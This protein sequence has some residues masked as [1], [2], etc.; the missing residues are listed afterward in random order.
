MP[1]SCS[2][3]SCYAIQQSGGSHGSGAYWIQPSS[4]PQPIRAYCDMETSGGGWTLLLNNVGAPAL[5][6]ATT[7]YNLNAANPSLT[8][9]H[10]LLQYGNE[11]KANL[12]GARMNY[13]IDAVSLGRW[14]GVW[15]APY[16]ANLETN[17][18]QNVATMIEKYD[19]GLWT[20]DTDP[21]DAN[22]TQ[23]PSNVI[24]WVSTNGFVTWGGSGNWWGAIAT[25]Q[26]GWLPTAPYMSAYLPSPSAIRY[27][28]K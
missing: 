13:R 14:G 7:Y 5:W 20:Q 21:N 16:S 19:P 2:Q 22:G 28:V 25:N 4:A 1:G 27:W 10:S 11:I 3:Q 15:D 26:S 9:S 17:T 18:P 24:P 23:T 12:S 6:N 8:Q